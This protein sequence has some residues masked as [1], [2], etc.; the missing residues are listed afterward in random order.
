[1]NMNQVRFP[2]KL[3]ILTDDPL[4]PREVFAITYL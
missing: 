3:L 4:Q 1:M 2:A